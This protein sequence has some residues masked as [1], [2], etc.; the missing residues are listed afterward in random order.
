VNA[1]PT[2]GNVIRTEN[3]NVTIGGSHALQDVSLT[4]PKGGVTALI[5]RNGVGK[6]TTLRALIGLQPSTGS[7]EINGLDV[8]GWP[9]HRIIRL[10]IGYVPEDR[11]VFTGLTVRENLRLAEISRQEPDYDRVYRLF[12]ELDKR[13]GQ[14]AGTLSG[15][16]QQMLAIGRVLLNARARPLLLVD[17]PAKGLAPRFVSEMVDVLEQVSQ[18]E[19]I[20]LVEQNVHVIRTLATRII[21]LDHGQVVHTGGAADLADA[22]LARR[23]LGVSG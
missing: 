6:T 21:V 14:L 23:L 13:G 11:D 9:V 18:L 22:D 12:P 19:T 4:I 5:G 3:L 17:E 2:A 7:I 16:Q 1:P 20:L 8:T 15:G 10:G